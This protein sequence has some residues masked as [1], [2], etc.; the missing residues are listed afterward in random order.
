MGAGRGQQACPGL[1][2]KT[3]SEPD[4]LHPYPG[5]SLLD[6]DLTSLSFQPFNHGH[7]VAKFCYADKSLLNKAIEAALAARKE[8]DLKP[9]ADRA[10]IFLKAADMLSGPHRA[11]IL[12]K[13]MVG[14]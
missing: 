4:P 8:W 1:F 9:I 10:Q 5:T 13:T 11:E 2:W 12:A 7:K 6:R 14:Q 3:S